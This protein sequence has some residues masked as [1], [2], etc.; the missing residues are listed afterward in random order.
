MLSR[1]SDRGAPSW[2]RWKAM[3]GD[4]SWHWYECRP[5]WNRKLQIWS[6][7]KGLV[8]EA[9]NESKRIYN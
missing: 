8:L 3:D 1:I 7:N 9:N 5:R 6:T 4:G 2:A